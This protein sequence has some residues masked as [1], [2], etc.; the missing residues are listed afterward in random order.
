MS[1]VLE[2]RYEAANFIVR[3]AGDAG[4]V[5]RRNLGRGPAHSPSADLDR[6]R[7]EALGDA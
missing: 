2:R 7:P 5:D 1:F 4:R 3:S 6:P